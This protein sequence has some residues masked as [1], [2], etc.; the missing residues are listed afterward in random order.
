[1]AEKT[2]DNINRT[3][4]D[5]HQKALQA[6]DRNNLDYAI[7]MFIQC[8]AIEPNFVKG[9]HYLRATQMK[10]AESAGRLKQMMAAARTAP[11]LT[12]AKMA[13]S[14]NPTEAMNLAEK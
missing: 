11:L 6:L 1:M 9:R 8:L 5:F 10:R 4:K 7:E 3:A 12:K 14:K 13:V 2:I